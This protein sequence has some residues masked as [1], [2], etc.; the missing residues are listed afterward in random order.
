[1]RIAICQNF[2]L[3]NYQI[4]FWKQTKKKHT[5]KLVEQSDGIRFDYS[6][7]FI[8]FVISNILSSF[9]LMHEN[10]IQN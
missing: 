10:F 3:E 9:V 5:E 8:H 1:M 7:L 2:R 4:L 6:Y